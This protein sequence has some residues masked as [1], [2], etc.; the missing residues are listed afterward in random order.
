MVSSFWDRRPRELHEVTLT[1]TFSPLES[2]VF[3]RT[4]PLVFR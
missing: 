2:K 1:L 4:G 3:Q